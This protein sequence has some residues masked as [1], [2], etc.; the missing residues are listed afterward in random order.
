VT[1]RLPP[2]PARSTAPPPPLLA[3]KDPYEA[4]L[5]NLTNALAAAR[6][7]VDVLVIKSKTQTPVTPS[8]LEGLMAEIDRANGI[9]KKIRSE[10]FRPGDVLACSDC[11]HRF[12]NRRSSGK[13]VNCRRCRSANVDRWTPPA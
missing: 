10:T 6:S 4:D 13:R 1:E 8:L 3:P 9:I 2:L 12:V 11:G 5:H 7:F